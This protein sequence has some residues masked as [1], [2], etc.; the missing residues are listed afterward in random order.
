MKNGTLRMAFTVL[1]AVLSAA[2]AFVSLYLLQVIYYVGYSTEVPPII[3]SVL[4][5]S[6][7]FSLIGTLIAYRV[8]HPAAT[9]L[10]VSVVL[11]S[12]FAVV[13]RL[14]GQV[15]NTDLFVGTLSSQAFAVFFASMFQSYPK[16]KSRILPVLSVAVFTV[17]SVLIFILTAEFYLRLGQAYLPNIVVYVELAVTV[18][19]A[20]SLLLF[21]RP[22]KRNNEN[23]S[24][25]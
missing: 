4:F 15:S 7:V 17:L 2:V 21:A 1:F 13:F 25:T 5:G 8:K 12:V 10:V 16:V 18:M 11:A 22:Q 24:H 19:S 20:I 3:E 23:S 6:L 9:G 14:S